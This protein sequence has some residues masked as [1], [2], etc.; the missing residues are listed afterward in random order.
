[1]V[2]WCLLERGTKPLMTKTK[3]GDPRDSPGIGQV[4]FWLQR[5]VV[6]HRTRMEEPLVSWLYGRCDSTRVIIA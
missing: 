2:L 6:G 3:T 1:M 4:E 5:R